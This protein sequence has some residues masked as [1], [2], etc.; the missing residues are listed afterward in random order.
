MNALVVLKV[1]SQFRTIDVVH[2]QVIPV[3][4]T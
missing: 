2:L 4:T 3:H 1:P